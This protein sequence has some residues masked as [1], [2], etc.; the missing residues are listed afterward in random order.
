LGRSGTLISAAS[1]LALFSALALLTPAVGQQGPQPV[2][3]SDGDS[4]ALGRERYRLQGIDAPELHQECKDAAGRAW[5]CGTRA[6][7]ELRRIIGTEPVRCRTVTT[8]R[9]GRNIAVCEAGGRDLAEEMVRSGYA[10]VIE[11]RGASSPYR[12]AQAEAR[13]GKRGIWA[14]TF[15]T[16]SDWRR[17]N[18]RVD[19][20]PTQSP[21]P[22][23]WLANKVAE[24]W[25][26]LIEWF[27]LLF[28][29]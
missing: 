18:P 12:S 22:R 14:G 4:F 6:R 15:D 10:T 9:Y 19:D 5:P 7:S 29:R 11:R 17:S 25:Q 16:P 27:G 2:R 26:A 13:A 28:G 24:L 21:S 23:D 3:L 8:D 20:S 1:L